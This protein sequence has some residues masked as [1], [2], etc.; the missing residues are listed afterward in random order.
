LNKD[1]KLVDDRG[2]LIGQYSA[3]EARKKAITMKKDILLVNPT[4]SPAICKLENF[5]LSI[6]KKFYEEIVNKRN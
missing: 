5:R 1:V 4:V 6:L 3:S 2:K